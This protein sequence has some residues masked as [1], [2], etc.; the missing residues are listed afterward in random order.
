MSRCLAILFALASAACAQS[1][2]ESDRVAE[3][4]SE[5]ERLAGPSTLKCDIS[6]VKPALTY[7]FRF[8]TGYKLTFPMIQFGGARQ[9][10]QVHVRVT[11]E[12]QQPV[13]LS[14]T[15]ALPEVPD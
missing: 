8:Q 9:R 13:Y 14:T 1:L 4:R 2:V 12:G 5:F 7:A 15:K 11:P 10:M 3:I 6:P